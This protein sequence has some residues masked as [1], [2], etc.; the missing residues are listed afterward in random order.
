MSKLQSVIRHEYVT[1]VK[2]RSFWVAMLA[3]PLLIGTAFGLSYIGNKSSENRIQELAKDLKN[4]AVVDQ[5]GLI[6]SEIVEG[7]GLK[8]SKSS[9]LETLREQVRSEKLEALIVYPADLRE[10]RNYDIYLS[11]NDLTKSSSV[12]SLGQNLL[13]TSLFLPLGSSDIIALAQNGAES[14]ITT[15]ENGAQTAGFNEYV[16]PGVFVVLFYIIF[17][18]SVSYM[19]SSISEEKENR[20]MEMVLTY[21]R[22]QS[23]IVGKLL[24]V[25][26]VTLTQLCFFA[27][28]G[29]IAFAIALG[30][31]NSLSLPAGIDINQLVFDPLAIFFGASFLIVGFL[32]FAGFMTTTAAMA[33]SAKE[34]NN[35]SAVFFVGAF[36]P[37]YFVMM[38]LTDPENPAVRFLT[39]FPL[40]SPVVTL[41]RN[42]VGNMSTLE[43]ALALVTM[44]ACMVLSLAIAIRAFSKGSLEFSNSIKLSSLLKRE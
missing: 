8:I 41:L 33:P 36:I 30:L 11:G 32:M 5:S 17:A 34:A 13:K 20:S 16:V 25:I 42:A 27:L 31:G 7:A 35:F 38:I 21:V 9:Q 44:T 29:I 1:I 18:F 3:I 12:S 15:Y 19:L 24:A 40:T 2:Q 4:V 37:F 6:R 28:L 23:L 39:F 26:L 14:T 43:S 10:T 22:G